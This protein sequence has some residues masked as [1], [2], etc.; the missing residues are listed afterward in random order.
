VGSSLDVELVSLG[1]EQRD[2]VLTMARVRS[3]D[4][5]TGCGQ[6]FDCLVNTRAPVGWLCAGPATGVHVKVETVL[7]RR[8][9]L[10]AGCIPDSAGDR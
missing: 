3:Y 5:G 10:S 7:G 9:G 2:A 1:I 8:S 6:P 4:G